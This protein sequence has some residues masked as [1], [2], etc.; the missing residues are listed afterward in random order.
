MSHPSGPQQPSPAVALLDPDPVSRDL[1]M[2]ALRA[3][4]LAPRVLHDPR[5]ALALARDGQLDLIV[6]ELR[7]PFVNGPVFLELLR[8]QAPSVPVIFVAASA[9]AAEVLQALRRGRAFDLFLKP[10]AHPQDLIVSIHL[11]LQRQEALRP[12]RPARPAMVPGLTEREAAV[13]A[14]LTEGLAPRDIAQRL[15]LKEKAVRNALSSLYQRLGVTGRT[16]AVLR[17]L[18][19]G[20]G[21][22]RQSAR[23]PVKRAAKLN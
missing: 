6:T 1:T 23:P 20:L 16:Q 22:G 14:L 9:T 17:C 8:E 5:E 12:P 21:E 18:E 11:A 13:A 10:L 4:D 19:L 3:G 15:G 2:A 7:L